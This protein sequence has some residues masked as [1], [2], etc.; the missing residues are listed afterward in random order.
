MGPT[1]IGVTEREGSLPTGA[2]IPGCMDG[3]TRLAFAFPG[4]I[5]RGLRAQQGSHGA[6]R[7]LEEALEREVEE[8]R[9]RR[10]NG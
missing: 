7:A 3:G 9:W 4:A 8:R 1:P 10:K 2:R 5:A 6:A